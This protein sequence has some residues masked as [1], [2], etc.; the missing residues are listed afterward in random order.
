MGNNCTYTYG[1]I[2]MDKN[3]SGVTSKA[4]QLDKFFRCPISIEPTDVT[5]MEDSISN[6]KAQ[7]NNKNECFVEI[8]QPKGSLILN[9]SERKKRINKESS[10]KNL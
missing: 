7:V 2:H 1:V 8:V 5:D 3:K 4:I 6:V 10:G 9:E